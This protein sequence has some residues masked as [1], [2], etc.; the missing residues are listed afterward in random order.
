MS[1]ANGSLCQGAGQRHA[2]RFRGV[3]IKTADG[4]ILQGPPQTATVLATGC[5]GFLGRHCLDELVRQGF[6]VHAV[7]RAEAG[8]V[9]DGIAWHDVDL[10]APGAVRKLVATL[11][12]SHLLHLA[13]IATPDLYRYSPQ[14]LD[15]LEASL[16]LVRVF[17]EHG[18]QR[19]VGV[20]TATEYRADDGPCREDNTPI[21]P[22]TLYGRCKSAF[23]MAA[24]AYAQHY[25]FSAAWGRVFT[26]YGPGDSLQRLIPSLVAAFSAGRPIDVTDGSQVR[27]FIYA[28]DVAALLVRL[29]AASTATGAFN[30]GTGR[31]IA[32][33]QVI[34]WTADC[35]DA[36]DLVHPG[37]RIKRDDEP[38][39]LV[40]DM[41]KVR[42]VLDW[43]APTSIESGLRQLMP[44]VTAPRRGWSVG[45]SAGSRA[46]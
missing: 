11:R 31:G 6:R 43:Q 27:D 41:D 39:S 38:S 19:F 40:A 2:P 15:W 9:A 20:G 34:E 30:V 36:H 35:F 33:R 10:M 28:P 14:N 8:R 18:G 7:S 42:R 29:V 21:S 17:G 3:I 12:P 45:Q 1:W 32:V 13:W 16:A 37:A 4:V 46:S 24:Q 44:K 5:T 23:W 26:P 25:G 22:V